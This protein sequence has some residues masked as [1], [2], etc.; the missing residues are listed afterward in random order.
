MWYVCEVL[1]AVLY[2]RVRC[3]VVRGRVVWRRYINVC[4][5]DM[6][7]VVN[8]YIDH[9]FQGLILLRRKYIYITLYEQ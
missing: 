4:N 8:V 7:S 6:F 9:C 2:V 3:F 1:Y 5:C